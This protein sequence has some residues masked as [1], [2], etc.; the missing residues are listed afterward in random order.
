MASDEAII[1]LT[2][3]ITPVPGECVRCG[4][5]AL[6]HVTLNHLTSQGVSTLSESTICGRCADDEEQP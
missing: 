6:V 5:D 4:F 3:I 1:Q 2:P